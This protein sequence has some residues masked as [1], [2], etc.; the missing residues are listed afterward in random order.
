M[1]R[2]LRSINGSAALAVA[3]IQAG[4]AAIHLDHRLGV[5]LST[6]LG[7]IRVGAIAVIALRIGGFLRLR[8]LYV[9]GTFLI[10]IGL[11]LRIYL[12]F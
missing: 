10:Q 5:T 3:V 1:G 11:L 4:Q 6:Q 7:A 8:G 9:F 12:I 2:L